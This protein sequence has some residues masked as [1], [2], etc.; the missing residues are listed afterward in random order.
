MSNKKI[1]SL[2]LAALG[3]VYGDIGTSPLYSFK[4]A[5]LHGLALNE[6]NILSVLSAFIWSVL[7]IVTVKYISVVMQY[8][9]NGEGGVL[10]LLALVLK[11]IK[12][13]TIIL[14][15]YVMRSQFL[16]DIICVQKLRIRKVSQF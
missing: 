4:E 3:V 9:N 6:L 8:N 16:L 2:A 10:S 7:L 1:S 14:P 15:L 13:L 12:P 11:K 5:L